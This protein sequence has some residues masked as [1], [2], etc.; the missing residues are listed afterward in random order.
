MLNVRQRLATPC[1]FL[2]E[3]LDHISPCHALI[4]QNC[5]QRCRQLTPRNLDAI[6]DVLF[7]KRKLF[8]NQ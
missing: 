1:R 5:Q 8:K 7:L 4:Y 6:I 2:F 3:K